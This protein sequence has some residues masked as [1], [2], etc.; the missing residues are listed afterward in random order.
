VGGTGE[1][2]A[3]TASALS[4]A[5]AAP[6]GL[7]SAQRLAAHRHKGGGASDY[8]YASFYVCSSGAYCSTPSTQFYGEFFSQENVAPPD[9]GPSCSVIGVGPCQTSVCS[10]SG[11]GGSDGSVLHPAG[12]LTISGGTLG[13]VAVTTDRKEGYAYE[14]SAGTASFGPGEGVTIAGS[15]SSA[16]PAFGAETLL[17]PDA[18]ELTAPA[19]NAKG[20]FSVSTS[21]ALRVAWSGG[22]D[23]YAMTFSAQASGPGTAVSLYCDWEAADG[24][25]KVPADQMAAF[26][27]TT[28]GSL[29]WGEQS[30]KEFGA[31]AYEVQQVAAIY[32]SGPATFK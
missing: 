7:R 21:A 3:T 23:G 6:R 27:G 16:V 8:A 30:A 13:S 22:T 10:T 26:A 2:T 31:G 18:V 4:P 11:G 14:W 15:G 1:T 12:T 32:G 19:A 29:T 9:S 5:A 24:E 17:A 25:D 20:S 28:D